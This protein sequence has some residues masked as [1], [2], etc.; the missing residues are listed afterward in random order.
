MSV[1]RNCSLNTSR[2]WPKSFRLVP[3]K[4]RLTRVGAMCDPNK[5]FIGRLHRWVGRDDL[6]HW[7]QM[8]TNTPPLDIYILDPPNDTALKSAF[9]TYRRTPHNSSGSLH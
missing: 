6:L 8:I 3:Q 2:V 4:F 5:L 7:M 9:V 1:F